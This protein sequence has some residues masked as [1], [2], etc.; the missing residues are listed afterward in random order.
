MARNVGS[1]SLPVLVTPSRDHVGGRQVVPYRCNLR[2]LHLPG[3]PSKQPQEAFAEVARGRSAWKRWIHL[4]LYQDRDK[5]RKALVSGSGRMNAGEVLQ[6]IVGI[7]GTY[8][9]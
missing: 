8:A 4:G 9:T 2:Q 6:V 3:R 7:L 1:G 5:R